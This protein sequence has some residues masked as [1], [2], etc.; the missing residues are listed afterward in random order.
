MKIKAQFIG[1]PD[2][3]FPDLKTGKTY[4][5]TLEIKHNGVFV[6]V[7]VEPI[8]CPYTSWETFYQNWRINEN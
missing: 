4:N 6:P 3:V 7:I 5:L 8:L 1:K 2:S